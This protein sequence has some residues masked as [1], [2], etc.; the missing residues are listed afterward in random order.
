MIIIDSSALVA[1]RETTAWLFRRR[2]RVR[3]TGRSMTPTLQPGDQV[4]VDG[5]L[6]PTVDGL[7]VARHPRTPDLL[8]IKRVLEIDEDGRLIVGSDNPD[9][10][11]D[12]RTWGPLTPSDVVGIVTW[13]FDRPEAV[14]GRR[15]RPP[16]VR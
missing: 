5:S 1:F 2:R 12:S 11:T 10:G 13:V 15:R 16:L 9:E 8:V 7:V 4:L 3:V 6:A 14:T